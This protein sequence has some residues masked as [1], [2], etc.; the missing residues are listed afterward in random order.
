MKLLLKLEETG[1]LILAFYLGSLLGY[2]WWMFLLF[3]FT[4][5]ISML[6]YLFG[7]K[8]GAVVYNLFHHKFFAIAVGITG[9]LLAIP[10]ITYAGIILFGH[11]SLDRIMGYGLKLPEG[12][13]YTHL[14]VIGKKTI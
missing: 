9:H 11:S 6:G 12:F 3:I 1:M 10:V 5:D 2:E 7:N 14:G 13:N 8:A 4:P